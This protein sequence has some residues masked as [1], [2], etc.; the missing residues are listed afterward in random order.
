MNGTRSQT[1]T[2]SDSPLIANPM[3][4]QA[5]GPEDTDTKQDIFSAIEET[6]ET[7]ANEASILY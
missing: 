3:T 7:S 4:K 2:V 5:S 1:P 6:F